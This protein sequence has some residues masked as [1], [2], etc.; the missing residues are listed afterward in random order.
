MHMYNNVKI[1]EK[2]ILLC[3]YNCSTPILCHSNK[4]TNTVLRGYQDLNFLTVSFGLGLPHR[5]AGGNDRK[6][7][8]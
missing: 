8:R 4:I 7:D 5:L 3:P 2:F 1:H 6:I